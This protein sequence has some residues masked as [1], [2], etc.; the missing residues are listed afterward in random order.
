MLYCDTLDDAF[1][2]A[3]GSCGGFGSSI[4]PRG[5]PTHDLLSV[6][7][8]LSDPRARLIYAP[9]RDMRYGYAAASVAWNLA[10]MDDVETICWWNPNGRRMSDDG[11]TFYGANYGQRFMPYLQEAIELLRQD[12]DT[13]RAWVPIWHPRDLVDWGTPGG[14]EHYSRE[15]KDVPCTL[16]F[17]LRILEGMLHMQVVMRS[18]NVWGVMP[19]DVFL[20]SVLQELI[21]NTVD[22]PLGTLHWAM[23]SCHLYDRDYDAA[24][25]V[26]DW[27]RTSMAMNLPKPSMEPIRLRLDEAMV[28]YPES[29]RAIM[30]GEDCSHALDP[31]EKMMWEGRPREYS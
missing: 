19:Y 12:N 21:A 15:G 2:T 30:T 6:V 8:V 4:S 23:L 14:V 1:A 10:S 20:L 18:Q 29:M 28:R 3:L 25:K 22:V 26:V 7:F 27:H 5:M 16:G 31:V 24:S 11:H 13:R 17:G 9:D